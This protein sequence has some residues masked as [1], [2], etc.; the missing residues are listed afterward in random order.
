MVSVVQERVE[1]ADYRI[2]DSSKK[3]SSFGPTV[4]MM[5]KVTLGIEIANSF[6]LGI[7]DG[8]EHQQGT[9]WDYSVS[10]VS[11]SITL[12]IYHPVSSIEIPKRRLELQL[13]QQSVSG[14]DNYFNSTTKVSYVYLCVPS[15][16]L[17]SKLRILCA[18]DIFWFNKFCLG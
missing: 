6:P 14:L 10:P 15:V 12:L 9:R 13:Q 18:A 2:M 16:A 8:I 1:L 5:S 11:D 3:P 7:H 4:A 17:N